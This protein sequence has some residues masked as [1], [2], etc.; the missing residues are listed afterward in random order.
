MT[1]TT[2]I[3][4]DATQMRAL[5]AATESAD[6]FGTRQFP[7]VY[8]PASTTLRQLHEI[9]YWVKDYNE[10]PEQD[11]DGYRF[12]VRCKPEDVHDVIEEVL[13]VGGGFV[14]AD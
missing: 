8:L 4:T 11:E 7:I 5:A 12:K 3:I 9:M 13:K 1:Q 14:Q 6:W 2:T 10:E